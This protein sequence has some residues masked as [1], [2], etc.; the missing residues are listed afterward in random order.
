MRRRRLGSELRRLRENAG[1]TGEQVIERVNWASASK[2]SR[3]ENGRSRPGVGDVM[4]LLDLYGVSDEVRDELVGIARDAGNTRAFLRSYAVM[5]SRQ[6]A[7]AEL[8]AGA[9]EIHEYGSVIIP[10][11]LQTPD[12]AKIR[13]LSALPLF[14]P[15]NDKRVPD[16]PDTEVAAR[17]S[18]QSMLMRSNG[19]PRYTAVLEETALGLRCGPPDVMVAQLMH[20]RSMAQ[21]PNVTLRVLPQT[22]T[23]ASWYL[24]ETAFSIYSFADPEDPSAVAVETLA[25]DMTVNEGPVLDRYRQVF[26]WM[27]QAA[28]DPE[29]SI[30]WLTEAITR[31]Q[32]AGATELSTLPA[33]DTA[34]P[35]GPH[36]DT[37]PAVATTPPTTPAPLS[38]PAT[39]SGAGPGRPAGPPI[40]RGPHDATTQRA[41]QVTPD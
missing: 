14:D 40:Q 4:D 27:C 2:L 30:E 16:D 35:G 10:G 41:E 3:L 7:Y 33:P 25:A 15:T 32:A 9:T 21:L 8:E 6:R 28:R 34:S 37:T 17:T 31:H 22:A 36:A 19:V 1:L 12:Y 5:T 29:E 23:I 24:P 18:R 38:P 39:A 26:D 20:L 11:L 13:I